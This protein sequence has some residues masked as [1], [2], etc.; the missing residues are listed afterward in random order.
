[1]GS[2]VGEREQHVVLQ[3]VE[4]GMVSCFLFADLHLV[5]LSLFATVG[6]CLVEHVKWW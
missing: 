6:C 5:L 1:M 4:D 3:G 2:N